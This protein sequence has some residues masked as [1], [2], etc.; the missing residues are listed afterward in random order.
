MASTARLGDR[1]GRDEA[2][3]VLPR[4]ARLNGPTPVGDNPAELLA[5]AD[6]LLRRICVVGAPSPLLG[7]R[8]LVAELVWEANTGAGA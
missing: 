1:L 5:S 2:L 4:R 3:R 7:L 8:A 6:Q